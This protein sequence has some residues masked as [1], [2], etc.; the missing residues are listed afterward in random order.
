MQ[1][2]RRKENEIKKEKLREGRKVSIWETV[3]IRDFREILE[4]AQL[5]PE[6]SEV[7]L[8]HSWAHLQGITS[9]YRAGHL[10]LG[11]YISYKLN[12]HGIEKIIFYH[13]LNDR[14]IQT[15][16]FIKI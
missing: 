10:P 16:K 14:K 11:V 6:H 3:G 5:C 1:V 12:L 15:F 9:R 7:C 8:N 4:L 13:V 2:E